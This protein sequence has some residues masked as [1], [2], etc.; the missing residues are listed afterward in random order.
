MNRQISPRYLTT[1]ALS[2]AC[3]LVAII[4]GL[5]M[6]ALLVSPLVA[7]V[8][9]A[10]A[11]HRWPDLDVALEVPERVVEGDE[12]TLVVCVGSRIGS[13]WVALNLELPPDLEAL[14]GTSRTI[15]TVRPGQLV[16]VRIPVRAAR[17]GVSVPGRI[18]VT[19]RDR[20]GF[21][22]TSFVHRPRVAIRVHPRD[23]ARR[24]VLAPSRLLP[25][26][27]NHRSRV[28]GEGSEF[29]EVRPYRRGDPQRTIN[30]R[31]SAR[32]GEPW[33]TVRHPDRSGDLVLMFDSF[34]DIGPLGDRLVQRA[35]RAALALAESNLGQYDRV[36]L[37]DVGRSIRWYR[38]RLGRLHEA[39][40][41]D[42]LLDTQVEPGLRA[43]DLSQLP[44]HDLDSGALIVFISGLIDKGA[45]RLP[46]GLRS[47]GHEVVVLECS[48][49]AHLVVNGRNAELAARLWRI[50]R[51]AQRRH[52]SDR[53]IA[54]VE[55]KPDDPL[56]IPVAALN[57]RPVAFR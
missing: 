18:S 35:V 21:F 13:P 55:W 33:V 38:P 48:A 2:A 26:A 28:L 53:G 36:G 51:A 40:L 10:P 31:V 54:V 9:V 52:L 47:R 27:G 29:A 44:L 25:R 4:A 17:W 22:A 39:R 23:G 37:L 15:V 30:W 3:L 16:K 14:Q 50:E 42:A 46:V 34:R 8:L 45:A 56:E 57:R 41:L 7:L 11:M 32:R 12:I 19:A 1:V 24:T 49:D 43:P 6:L 20:F 5:P